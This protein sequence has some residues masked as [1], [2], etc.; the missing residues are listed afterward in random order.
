MMALL[1]SLFGG[2]GGLPHFS[3]ITVG[4][5]E[6]LWLL[7]LALLGAFAGWLFFPF[8]ALARNISDAMGEHPVAKAALAGCLLGVA[9]IV[10]PFALFAGEAQ[11]EELSLIWTTLPAVALIV[12]GFVKVLVTQLCLNLGWHGGHF[13][14]IIFAGISLGYGMAALTGVDPIFA[15]CAVTAALIGAVMRHPLLTVA[16]L[17]LVFPLAAAP[18]LFVAAAVGALIPVPKSW[19][20]K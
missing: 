12:T 3:G 2:G 13:F 20:G 6:L 15:L 14:P 16:L 5:L 17:F 1:G 18:V 8:G 19:L 9:G 10:L 4:H 11:T 7:P